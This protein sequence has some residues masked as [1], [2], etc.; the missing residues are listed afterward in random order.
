MHI[1]RPAAPTDWPATDGA[2]ATCRLPPKKICRENM[3]GEN[4]QKLKGC[5]PCFSQRLYANPSPFFPG[6]WD[7]IKKPR[8]RGG[9]IRKETVGMGLSPFF[10]FFLVWHPVVV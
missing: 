4:T 5:A 6:G 1:A 9:A 7:A 3:A 10:T 8:V 2:H